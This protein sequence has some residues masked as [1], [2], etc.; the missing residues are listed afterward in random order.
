MKVFIIV[1]LPRGVKDLPFQ[2]YII[3]FDLSKNFKNF[4]SSSIFTENNITKRLNVVV[5]HSNLKDTGSFSELCLLFYI[6]ITFVFV[7]LIFKRDNC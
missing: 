7:V 4:D 6:Q 1:I 3:F 2:I 5:P